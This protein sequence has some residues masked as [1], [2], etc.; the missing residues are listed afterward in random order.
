MSYV[1]PGRLRLAGRA[2]LESSH[3]LGYNGRRGCDS[4]SKP[5]APKLKKFPPAKQRRMDELL[6]KQSEGIISPAERARL[7]QL[8]A[9]A[10][11][12]MVEN[13]KL[14]AA[15]AASDASPPAPGA[16]PVTVWVAPAPAGR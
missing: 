2:A 13:G 11:Q 15:F 10:E 16:V 7:Q 12:L 3:E 4:M 8:V 1:R 5:L 14:L 6:D 9:E